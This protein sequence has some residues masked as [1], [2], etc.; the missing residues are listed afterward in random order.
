MKKAFIIA[1][2]LLMTPLLSIADTAPVKPD[3]SKPV[4]TS[5]YKEGVHYTV[6]NQGPATSKPEITEFFSFYCPHCYTFQK[7]EVPKIK[8]RLPAGVT[9]KQV[10]VDFLG[11]KGKGGVN[12]GDVMAR[13]FAVAQLLKV[14]DKIEP[15][16]FSAIHDKRQRFTSL[17][18]VRALFVAN[19]VDGAEFDAA[20]NSF[21]VNAQMAQMVRETKDAGIN[22]VPTLIVNGKYRVETGA[23]KSY[24]DMLNIAFYLTTLK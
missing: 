15:A 9:F 3:V 12:M 4:V 7:T 20:A 17:D 13:A 16:I 23:I 8:K 5:K 10:Q 24:D 6:I 18:D 14:E 22:G 11:G 2:A 19:G 1:V 21:M